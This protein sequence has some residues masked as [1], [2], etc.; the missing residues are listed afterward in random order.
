MRTQK[1]IV[2]NPQSQVITGT[3]NAVKAVC[4]AVG[5][6]IGAVEPFNHLFIW[7]VLRGDGIAVDKSKDL[8]DFKRKRLSPLF[9]KF[10]CCKRIGT[11]AVSNEFKV[12]R[13]FCKSPEC[14]AHGKNAGTDTAVIRYLVA[15]DGT[16]RS[17]HDEPDKGFDAAYF[18]VG[19]IGGEHAALFVGILVCKG[20]DADCGC[21][22]I[23]GD[24]LVGNADVVQI[25]ECL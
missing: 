18:D 4:M 14:H 25:P 1:V 5:S 10:H 3:I 6:L 20:F 22:T 8:G 12:F 23:V 11:I 15:D 13:Q 24:L 19:L 16:G 7:A 17:I 2:S 9:S 21:F